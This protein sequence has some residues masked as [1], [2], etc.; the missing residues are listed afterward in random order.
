PLPEATADMADMRTMV[1]VGNAD[2]RRV[3]RFIY[4]PR[5]AG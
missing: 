3:G 1:I 2:T 5:R 4:S